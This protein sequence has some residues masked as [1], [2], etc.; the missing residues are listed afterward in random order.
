MLSGEPVTINGDGEQTRD[1]VYVEDCA[2]ANL[3][4]T[5]SEDPTGIF[6]LGSGKGTSVN[7]IF[8]VLNS[9]IDYPH[10]PIHGPAKIGETRHIHLDS[11]LIQEKFGWTAQWKLDAGLEET[12]RYFREKER[13]A[14]VGISSDQPG[15]AVE[16]APRIDSTPTWHRLPESKAAQLE[17]EYGVT[18]GRKI[19]GN[20]DAMADIELN[21]SSLEI[22][23]ST[24]L[25]EI[26]ASSGSIF[27]VD[28]AS[29]IR[30]AAFAYSG[31]VTS[32]A[33]TVMERSL[34]Q[35]LS[36]LV[37]QKGSA[38]LLEDTRK[39]ARWM[40]CDWDHQNGVGRSVISVPLFSKD[41]VVGVLTLARSSEAGF[42]K[43]ELALL[44]T[45]SALV[46]IEGESV[47]SP[48]LDPQ[49]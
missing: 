30:K 44:M 25:H 15:I 19:N 1:Y 34:Q 18:F 7:E 49:M 22:I 3:L 14:P 5:E 11:R 16:Q 2:R 12:L 36:G 46:S 32:G 38:V 20:V 29:R 17:Q 35:G 47:G 40:Q 13:L 23:L 6:N 43:H 27:L 39:D 33:S 9:L 24:V 10:E 26:D 21:D 28:D 41:R 8:E 48:E 4:V 37:I 31:K 45:I 42:A